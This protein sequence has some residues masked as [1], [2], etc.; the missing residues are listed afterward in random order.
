V[1]RVGDQEADAL[2]IR[3][4]RLRLV[5]IGAATLGTAA[6]VAASGLIGF[7]GI[8]IPHAVRLLAGSSFRVVLPLS[9]LFGAAF[10]VLADVV[11]RT[12]L[13]PAELPIGVVT[14]CIGAPFFVLVL[15][16]SR[17]AAA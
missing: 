1:L 7:V 17:E 2:G 10:L 3:V 5:V 8:I 4:G 11:A 6:A 9:M 12:L 15:R 13:S 14:A 16:T